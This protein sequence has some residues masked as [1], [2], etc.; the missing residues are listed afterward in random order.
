[1]TQFK[2]ILVV[3]SK[4]NHNVRVVAWYNHLKNTMTIQL[5]QSHD[6]AKQLVRNNSEYTT[7]KVRVANPDPDTLVMPRGIVECP[8]CGNQKLRR[9]GTCIQSSHK[10]KQRWLCLK[11]RRSFMTPIELQDG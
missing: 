8:A 4:L 9:R 5:A 11:C 6:E 2:P 10:R 1:M 3:T 7:V